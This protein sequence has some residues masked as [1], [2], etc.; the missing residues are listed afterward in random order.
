MGRGGFGTARRAE[1]G[2]ADEAGE[3]RQ[4]QTA[5]QGEQADQQQR[6][7][8]IKGGAGR[9]GLKQSPIDQPFADKTVKRGEGAD[10]QGAADEQ[11]AG[12]RHAFQHP[13][14]AVE[15][16]RPGAVQEGA[17]AEKHQAFKEGVIPDMQQPAGHG[18]H[19]DR[20]QVAGGGEP[21]KT[22]GEK[23]QADIFH[24]RIGQAAL[25]IL[26]QR[27]QGDAEEG[28]GDPQNHQQLAPP[29]RGGGEEADDA[30][31]AV[32]AGL[33]HDPG[34]QRRNVARRG[35]MGVRQP[36]VQGKE[37]R[38]RAEAD[39]REQEEE[40]GG[41]GGQ[42]PQGREGAEF[43][44]TA[45]VRGEEEE[46]EE[47]RRAEMGREQIEP[48]GFAHLLS[49]VVESDQKEGSQGHALPG[50]DEENRVGGGHHQDHG[51]DQEGVEKPGGAQGAAARLVLEIA[52]TVD[53][54]EQGEQKNWDEKEGGQRIEG[55]SE[56][57]AGNR[58]GETQ[59]L[60]A[61]FEKGAP[62][63]RQAEKGGDQGG[64]DAEEGRGCRSPP[65]AEGGESAGKQNEKR[66]QDQVHG[67]LASSSVSAWR[68]AARIS[69]RLPSSVRIF[70]NWGFFRAKPSCERRCR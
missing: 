67:R 58:P 49:P 57:A 37:P 64:G 65:A 35:G 10:R 18:E 1:Q 34:H 26:L 2:D 62:R 63:R 19:G 46:G 9:S 36:D 55:Q 51:G 56:A 50:G 70:L 23:D 22:E 11:G 13:P 33:D 39:Q 4:R 30:Q 53:G 48:G 8:G 52:V 45:P 31:N 20:R 12:H 68:S 44:G 28:A 54:A 38:L 27:G 32:D 21:G 17:G 15:I 69:S 41:A 43:G 40:G 14:H 6:P 25:D 59:G 7:E 66:R 42:L 16:T 5:D 47:R 29:G 60:G 24:R 61:L 3:D